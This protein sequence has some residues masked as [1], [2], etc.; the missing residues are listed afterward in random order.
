MFTQITGCDGGDS[1]CS[2]DNQCADGEGDCD[3]DGDCI[4]GICGTDN[5]VGE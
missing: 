3:Y 2:S 4:S 1:C 5:C